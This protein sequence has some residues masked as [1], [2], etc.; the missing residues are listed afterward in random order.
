M[1]ANNFKTFLIGDRIGKFIWNELNE[2]L[3]LKDID[4]L[5][6]KNFT[7][8]DKQGF[9]EIILFINELMKNQIITEVDLGEQ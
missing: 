6:K 3:S 2:Q 9:N 8:Y 1:N 7:G 5:M 4:V